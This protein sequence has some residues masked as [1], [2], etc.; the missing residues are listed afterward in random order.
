MDHLLLPCGNC[1][2]LPEAPTEKKKKIT[3]REVLTADKVSRSVFNDVKPELLQ[4]NWKRLLA[5]KKTVKKCAK[6]LK[7]QRT[8]FLPSLYAYRDRRGIM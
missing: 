5:C 7:V 2:F 8:I 4:I 6:D 3:E 1:L